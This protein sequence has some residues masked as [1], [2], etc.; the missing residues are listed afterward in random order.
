MS[1][2]YFSNKNRTPHQN[3]NL[4]VA[5]SLLDPELLSKSEEPLPFSFSIFFNFSQT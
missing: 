5:T 2:P 3:G 1:L 4:N